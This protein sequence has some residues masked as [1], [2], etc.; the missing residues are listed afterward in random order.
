MLFSQKSASPEDSFIAMYGQYTDFTPARPR[1]R[2]SFDED[3]TSESTLTDSL[4]SA[5][6]EV[7]SNKN[8]DINE[9]DRLRELYD[10]SREK[11]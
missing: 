1:K 4:K 9:R 10:V 3:A 2:K 6:M 5:S 7:A 11:V 8:I